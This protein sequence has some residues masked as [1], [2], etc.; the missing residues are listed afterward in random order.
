MGKEATAGNLTRRQ[1]VSAA[2]GTVGIATVGTALG[3]GMAH[4]KVAHAAETAQGEPYEVY[5]FDVLVCGCGYGGMSAALEARG[6]GMNVAVV[7]KAPFGSGGVTGMNFDFLTTWV[8]DPQFYAYDSQLGPVLN[9][10]TNLNARLANE[11]RNAAD[12]AV[13]GQGANLDLTA[14]N[15]G[16]MFPE[17]NEDGSY[18][19]FSDIETVAVYMVEGGFPR[20][21]LDTLT[22]SSWISVFDQTML[23]ELLVEN[24]V[25]CGAMGIYLPTGTIRVF[26]AKATVMATGGCCW[27]NGWNTVAPQSGSVPDNTADLEVSAFRH[28]AAIADSEW[29]DYDLIT[30][31]PTGIS[32]G[33]PAGL[34]ADSM[35]VSYILD[36]TGNA[37]LMD[38]DPT[39]YQADRSL[40]LQTVG[41]AILDGR[42]SSA[43]GVLV[44]YTTE[45]ARANIRYFYRRNID[46]FRDTFGIDPTSEPI[47]C[48]LEMIEHQGN[49]LV[50]GNAMSRD[51]AGLFCTRG[52][53]MTGAAGS[54]GVS[55]NYLY[56][57]YA[58][59]KALE[60]ADSS[61]LAELPIDLVEAECTRLIGLLEAVPADPLRPVQV[62]R[63]IQTV[64]GSCLGIIRQTADLETALQ[65][66]ARIRTE[67]LPRQAVTSVSRAYNTEWKEAIENCNLLTIAELSV[68][69]TLTREESRGSYLRPDFPEP[70]DEWACSLAIHGPEGSYTTEKVEM[71]TVDWTSVD[72]S[73]PIA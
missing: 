6:G 61:E 52:G 54:P 14:I 69:A 72:W 42:G 37:F 31:Y 7:E 10:E 22:A 66:L 12:P 36:N 55:H 2:A 46:L 9:E 49:I 16:Q 28:G 59:E 62:R 64:A 65:E 34:G 18:H 24:G 48:G 1:L 60:Y 47:E 5:E 44:D 57:S 23:T 45:E 17:R 35:S 67:D 15:H 11:R 19:V 38:G 27:I 73:E 43:G 20:H 56:G 53:G 30:V 39:A 13:S 3:Y 68:L 26:R 41:Q 33:Y 29:A 63:A 70:S 51:F 25:C 21:E 32:C 58:M 71:P 50:D 4:E 8:Y 40:F